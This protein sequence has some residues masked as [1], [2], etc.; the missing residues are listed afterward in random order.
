MAG[1]HSKLVQLAIVALCGVVVWLA[2]KMPSPTSESEP[3]RPPEMLPINE[4]PPTWDGAYPFLVIRMVNPDPKHYRFEIEISSIRPTVRHETSVNEFQ[5]D[6]HS[7]LFVL[8]Q[9]DL[10]VPDAMPLVLTRTY[11]PWFRFVRAFGMGTNHPYDI[12]PTGTRLPYTYQDL[13]LEDDRQIHFPRISKGT[14]YA[15]AVFRHGET[16][17]EFYG[18]QDAW[19]GNGWT[20]DFADGRRFLFPEAYRAKS[21]AQ[22]AATDMSDGAGHHIR[23]N[24]DQVRNLKQL[25]SPSGHAINFR[26]D[27]A[28]RIVEASDDSGTVRDYVYDGTGHLDMVT[29]GKNALYGFRYEP[30]LHESGYDPYVMTQTK[31]GNGTVLLQNEFAD[32][33]RVSMQKLADGRV[34]RY[35]YLYNLRHDIVRTTVTLPDGKRHQF[36]FKNGEPTEATEGAARKRATHGAGSAQTTDTQHGSTD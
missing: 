22:G 7:G 27:A 14:G 29:D 25:V 30:L 10:F 13:N 16:S 21:Y 8:R 35:E 26:Y 17:S 12:C 9:T 2:Y 24:R 23:L 36:F 5:V 28:N 15:D 31:D 3:L 32:G 11:R 34:V 19:N 1:S 20:L 6:L 4:P 18:A 33:S